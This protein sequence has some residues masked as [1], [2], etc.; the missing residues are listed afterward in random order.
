[1]PRFKQSVKKVESAP[2]K[3]GLTSYSHAKKSSKLSKLAK[4]SQ[5]VP[6]KKKH[7]FRPG[8]VAVRGIKKQQKLTNLVIQKRPFQRL[9]RELLLDH[10]PKGARVQ[11][12]AVLALQEAAERYLLT[13]Y[14]NGLL[15]AIH[16]RRITLTPKDITLA[17]RIRDDE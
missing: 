6:E 13:A 16:A 2:R 3:R 1:M 5:D 12:Q 7:R 9:V 17:L 15:C 8:T 14:E 4:A 10:F 11:E